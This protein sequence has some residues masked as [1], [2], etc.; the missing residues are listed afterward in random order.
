MSI[1]EI[2]EKIKSFLGSGTGQDI[3]LSL[4]I[5]L[6]ATASFGLS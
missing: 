5:L 1:K 4:I 6:V 2:H 3:F